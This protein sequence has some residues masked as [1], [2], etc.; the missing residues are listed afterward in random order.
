MASERAVSSYRASGNEEVQYYL[1]ITHRS[2]NYCSV[3]RASRE[4]ARTGTGH[5]ESPCHETFTAT[6]VR[7]RV[8]IL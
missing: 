8:K 2:A 7:G 1:L 3:R 6:A 4:E 5:A